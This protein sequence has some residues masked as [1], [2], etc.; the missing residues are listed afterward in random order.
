MK[1][2]PTSA[3]VASL[4]LALAVTTPVLA[5][6][7]SFVAAEKTRAL[8]ILPSPPAAESETTRLELAELHRLE[9]GRSEKDVADA[10]WD[11]TN[12]NVFL[13][14][15][16]FGE[17]FNAEALPAV[18]A[19]GKRVRND[20]GINSGPAKLGFHRVR[21]YNLDKTLN[22]VCK[23][24]TIDDS[25]PSGHATSGYLLALAM[26]DMVPEKRDEILA[27]AD[28]YARN[29]LVCGVHYP[30]DIAASK[31]L[32]YAVHAAMAQSPQYAIELAPAR[33][34][35]RGF[36]GLPEVK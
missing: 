26:I 21:P 8:E 18:A 12:E 9:A 13:F 35:M 27:R 34:E 24:K 10:K 3:L 28:G 23:T 20:E 11:E 19:F 6:D 5:R 2:S 1:H 22:P 29:R 14:T 15:T 16:I 7:P 33:T 30:S 36:L 31:L 32:A 4:V 17:K 25:Y